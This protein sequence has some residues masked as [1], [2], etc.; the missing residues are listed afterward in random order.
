MSPQKNQYQAYSI[1]TRTVAKTRQIIMLYDGAVRFLKQ[2]TVAIEEKRIEDRFNLLKKASDIMMG[3]HGAL[4]FENG[5]D[6]AHVLHR[7]Y[8]SMSMRMLSVNFKKKK[9][10]SLA[11]CQQLI[12]ELKQMRDVWENIDLTLNASSGQEPVAPITMPVE[13]TPLQKSR[14]DASAVTL[15]A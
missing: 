8:A 15:S 5:G 11:L 7:F 12:E 9:E 13:K 1:A 4:D 14:N 10:E 3:L 6:V 2:A